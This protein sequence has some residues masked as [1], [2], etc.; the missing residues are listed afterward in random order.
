MSDS[1]LQLTRSMSVNFKFTLFFTSWRWW[2][3]NVNCNP[4]N[5]TR[6]SMSLEILPW[7]GSTS[8]KMI[9]VTKNVYLRQAKGPG[10]EMC[11]HHG[12]LES[13]AWLCAWWLCHSELD[14]VTPA[15]HTHSNMGNCGQ[16]TETQDHWRQR[17]CQK[18]QMFVYAYELFRI[19]HFWCIE[20]W[21]LTNPCYWSIVDKV[22]DSFWTFVRSRLTVRRV[23]DCGALR[24]A[25]AN[26]WMTGAADDQLGGFLDAGIIKCVSSFHWHHPS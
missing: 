24:P 25:A 7:H 14:S 18:V 12:C 26:V 9:M 17:G 2:L 4:L 3:N 5:L 20:D 23:L 1:E 19:W 13:P 6:V 10:Q 22:L 16:E 15:G 8:L 21:I 11:D